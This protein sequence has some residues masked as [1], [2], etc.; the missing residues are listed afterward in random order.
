MNDNKYMKRYY[1]FLASKCVDEKLQVDLHMKKKYLDR[2][3]VVK[4]L[5]P[6]SFSLNTATF[7]PNFCIEINHYLIDV[8]IA[9]K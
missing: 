9:G 5:V 3:S 7:S 4:V 2:Q 8:K 6:W 1:G